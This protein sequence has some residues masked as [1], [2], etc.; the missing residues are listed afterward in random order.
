[1]PQ[2]EKKK[3]TEM[4]LASYRSYATNLILWNRILEIIRILQIGK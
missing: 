2:Y 1:M 4:R 3:E